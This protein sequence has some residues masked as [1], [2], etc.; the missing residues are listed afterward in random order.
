MLPFQREGC[1]FLQSWTC[2]KSFPEEQQQKYNT[3]IKITGSGYNS[4][5]LK[6]LRFRSD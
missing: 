6:F 3:Q 5:S 2:A 1:E 4:F